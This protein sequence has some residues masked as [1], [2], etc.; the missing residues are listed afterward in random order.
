MANTFDKYAHDIHCAYF[1][2]YEILV[3]AF[4]I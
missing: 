2:D 3:Y 4:N 1:E